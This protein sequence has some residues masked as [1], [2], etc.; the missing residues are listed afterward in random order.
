M[1]ARAAMRAVASTCRDS[2]YRDS[3][4]D[5]ATTMIHHAVISLKILACASAENCFSK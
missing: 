4:K 2:S 3:T 5:T 1:L